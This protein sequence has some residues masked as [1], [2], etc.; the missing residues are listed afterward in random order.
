M[1][2]IIDDVFGI[3]KEYLFGIRFELGYKN[4]KG[5]LTGRCIYYWPSGYIKSVSYYSNGTL[6]GNKKL[7]C[8]GFNT[9][10]NISGEKF[11]IVRPYNNGL[12]S[13]INYYNGIPWG[14]YIEWWPAGHIRYNSIYHFTCKGKTKKG[15]H[16]KRYAI[17]DKKTRC[18]Y[19]RKK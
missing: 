9:Y 5:N 10:Y 15:K 19:H 13:D 14:K 1:V 6:H 4:S 7:Y 12:V 8:N 18:V 11:P 3:V 17:Y 2:Y 16:C